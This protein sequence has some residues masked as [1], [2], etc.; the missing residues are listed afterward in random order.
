MSHARAG[1]HASFSVSEDFFTPADVLPTPAPSPVKA[2]ASSTAIAQSASSQNPIVIHFHFGMSGQFRT[3]PYKAVAAGQP[4]NLPEA[5]PTTRLELLNPQLGICVQLSCQSLDLGDMAFYVTRSAKLGPDPL[6]EDADPERLWEAMQ[7]TSKP[8]GQVLMDQA[9][10]AG[11][12][13]I[14][15]AEILYKSR[16]HPMVPS[17]SVSREKFEEIWKHSVELLQRGFTSGSILTVDAADV[18][19]FG[20][21][22]NRRYIY[23]HSRCSCGSKIDS[24][25]LAGRNCYA[26]P[27]CQPRA[28]GAVAVKVKE[29]KVFASKCAPDLETT[30]PEKMTVAW[31]KVELEKRGLKVTGKRSDLVERLQAAIGADAQDEEAEVVSGEAETEEKAEIKQEGSN[32]VKPGT[33]HLQMEGD[34][35]E[36]YSGDEGELDAATQLPFASASAAAAEK[37]S[38]GE[39]RNVEHVAWVEGEAKAKPAKRARSTR[40][41][42]A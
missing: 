8:I 36:I 4:H 38:A 34:G 26:C 20:K 21:P 29:V 30:E 35:E 13:N 2:S 27:K 24:W 5:K 14:Y 18:A 41:R 6:R 22:W 15:R 31:L 28:E 12:G 25:T 17:K 10:V 1:T 39:K 23:N 40:Q 3:V 11:I 9:L 37:A 16:L 32:T 42:S 19:K 7:A 33:M